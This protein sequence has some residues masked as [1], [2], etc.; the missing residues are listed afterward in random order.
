MNYHLMAY[1]RRDIL[2]GQR[3]LFTMLGFE[4]ILAILG[5]N[6]ALQFLLALRL[7]G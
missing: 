2:A 3:D 7:C 6:A 5:L 4:D 1:M